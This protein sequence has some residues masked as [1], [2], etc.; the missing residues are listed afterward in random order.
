MPILFLGGNIM[1][2]NDEML[3]E[4]L[5]DKQDEAETETVE[6][7]NGAGTYPLKGSFEVEGEKISGIEYDLTSVKPIQYMNL[8]ARLSKKAQISVPELDINVQIGYFSL[9]CGIP[10]SDLKRMPNTQDFTVVCAKVRNF[11]LG[12]SDMESEED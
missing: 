9:A 4:E 6:E 1:K 10:V 8:I 12:T 7:R 2:K 11:L 3:E 5:D